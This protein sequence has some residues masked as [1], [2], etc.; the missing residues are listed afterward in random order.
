MIAD[1]NL[2]SAGRPGGRGRRT[3]LTE[4]YGQDA[5]RSDAVQAA[6]CGLCTAFF[7]VFGASGDENGLELQGGMGYGDPAIESDEKSTK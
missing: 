7:G 6:K 2:V 3:G 1:T 5:R 4:E